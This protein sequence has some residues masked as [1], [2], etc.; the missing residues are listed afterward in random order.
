MD[1]KFRL[2]T[3]SVFTKRAVFGDIKLLLVEP[4]FAQADMIR[5]IIYAVGC[6]QVSN[7]RSAEE[8]QE[9]LD[10]QGFDI[11]LC[12]WNQPQESG[13]SFCNRLRRNLQ[14][15]YATIPLV[16]Y[17][18]K[19]RLQ[20]VI[21]ARDSGIHEYLVMPFSSKALIEKLYMVVEQPRHFLF[22]REFVGPDRRRTNPI[23]QIIQ[24]KND[25]D[26]IKRTPAPIVSRH[27][28]A[29]LEL[30]DEPRMALP[31]YSLKLKVGL[32]VPEE[33]QLLSN[34]TQRTLDAAKSRIETKLLEEVLSVKDHF[35]A[36]QNTD[37]EAAMAASRLM[38]QSATII[39]EQSLLVGYNFA[40]D[41][42]E[43]L[44]GFCTQFAQYDNP[45]HQLIISKHIDILQTVYSQQL[46]GDGGALGAEMLHDLSRLIE[47]FVRV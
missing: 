14:A 40:M 1:E 24:P 25:V 44:L 23:K 17:S 16:L 31:D 26:I 22:S 2:G 32:H 9:M 18:D 19:N 20:D 11:I 36:M 15:A 7:A 12:N 21:N 5:T 43:M 13:V 35:L 46:S 34:A 30:G 3:P 29:E 6:R 8:A 4:D 27:S 10:A 41:I 37:I 39:A 28:L 47:K 33:L 45:N 42:A 38:Q